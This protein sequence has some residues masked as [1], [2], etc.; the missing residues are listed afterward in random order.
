[1]VSYL[2]LGGQ[3]ANTPKISATSIT[4]NLLR[5]KG[6]L[7]LYRGTAATML[8]DVSFSIVYFPLFAHLNSLGPRKADGSGITFFVFHI[9]NHDCFNVNI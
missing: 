7:G 8:R 4:L 2:P 6:I 5:E 1:M 9:Q 3:V